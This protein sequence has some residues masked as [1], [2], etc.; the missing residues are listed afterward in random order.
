MSLQGSHGPWHTRRIALTLAAFLTIVIMNCAPSPVWLISLARGLVITLATPTPAHSP[1]QPLLTFSAQ[2]SAPPGALV[3][4]L[5]SFVGRFHE[6]EGPDCPVQLWAP[7]IGNSSS[8]P[9][10]CSM[11]ERPFFRLEKGIRDVRD[12][13]DQ[14]NRWINYVVSRWG[15]GENWVRE[16]GRWA[17]SG[18]WNFNIWWPRRASLRDGD[19]ATKT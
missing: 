7:R 2:L 18:G 14:C 16:E 13:S 8:P 9:D 1:S 6:G 12:L 4:S 3:V 10:V 17:M 15:S 5:I 11:N 19:I